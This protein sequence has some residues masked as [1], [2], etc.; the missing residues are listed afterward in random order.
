MNAPEQT[1]YIVQ[2]VREA[3]SM[4][5]TDARAFLAEH[6]G[7]VRAGALNEALDSIREC[8]RLGGQQQKGLLVAR[9]RILAL[10]EGVAPE[11]PRR[12]VS[13]KQVAERCR[14]QPGE[15]LPVGEYVNGQSAGSIVSAIEK[16]GSS[17]LAY[18]PAGTFE[19]R[20]EHTETGTAVY[21]RYVGPA[22]EGGAT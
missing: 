20:S 6:D 9:K 11:P 22:V 10:I 4:Y 18:L 17:V 3:G 8:L 1:E 14:Q 5:E 19:G 21:A 12:N 16:G 13:H 2:C 15:W 7:N